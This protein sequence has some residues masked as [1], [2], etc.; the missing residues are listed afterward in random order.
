[1]KL[2]SIFLALF[3]VTLLAPAPSGAVDI[4]SVVSK[5][6][7]RYES[8]DTLSADFS[9]EF[10]SVAAGRAESSGGRV[11][12]KKPSMM[13]WQYLRGTDDEMVSNGKV[14]WLFQPELNQVIETPAGSSRGIAVDFLSGVGDIKKNFEV[15]NLQEDG[16]THLLALTPIAPSA[17]LKRL[18]LRVDKS[19]GLVSETV[20]LDLFGNRTTVRFSDVE[21]NVPIEDSFFEFVAPDGVNLLKQ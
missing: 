14:L 17:N 9:Q 12:L 8:I 2:W 21:I 13:R 11:Y 18:L 3:A 5:L 15:S 10:F 4:D 7:A 19:T 20:V 1:M 16:G 6:Q